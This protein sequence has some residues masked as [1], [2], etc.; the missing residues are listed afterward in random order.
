LIIYD[1]SAGQRTRGGHR[2]A[3]WFAT[4]A[5]RYPSPPGYALDV[6]GLPYRRAGLRL[7]AYEELEIAV[8]MTSSAYLSYVL[9]ATSVEWAIARG[10]PETEIRAWC[11]NTLANVFGGRSHDV[12]FA[13][14]VAYVSRD[15]S[16]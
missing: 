1:F 8:P 16:A 12:L 7:Q 10:V 11:Q 15:G 2:L 13:A 9:S 5:R 14:Y 6:R 4:F 3:A